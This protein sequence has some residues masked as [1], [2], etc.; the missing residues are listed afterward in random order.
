[1]EDRL[2]RHELVPSQQAEPVP[3]S[4]ALELKVVRGVAEANGNLP[5]QDGIALFSGNC[6]LFHGFGLQRENNTSPTRHAFADRGPLLTTLCLLG[7][8]C[9]VMKRATATPPTCCLRMRM[10]MVMRRPGA[11]RFAAEDAT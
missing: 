5:G 4:E 1:L 10:T 11:G 6:G 7:S 3:G 8:V 9:R 2:L